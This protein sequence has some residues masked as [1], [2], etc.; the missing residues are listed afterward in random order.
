MEAGRRVE[1]VRRDQAQAGRRPR[2][3]G[4]RGSFHTRGSRQRGQTQE[5]DR[6]DEHRTHPR[7]VRLDRHAGYRRERPEAV[8]GDPPPRQ[9]V[10]AL[11]L[12]AA[13]RTRHPQRQ[14]GSQT[15]RRQHG[16]RADLR[17]RKVARRLQV[18]AAAQQAAVHP[19]AQTEPYGRAYHRRRRHG[20]RQ[21]HELH[22]IRGRAVGQHRLTGKGPPRKEDRGAGERASGVRA[23]QVVE[24]QPAGIYARKNRGT[25]RKDR[26]HRKRPRSFQEPC[27]TQRGRIV[28][29]PYHAGRGGEQRSAVHRQTT[30]PYRKNR[31]YGN[32]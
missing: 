31:R 20:R 23:R 25:R 21:R 24:P 29:Q 26:T 19:P 16:G 22:G 6:R 17:R 11:G 4:F 10:A 9:S 30:E 7:I 1:R 18:R 32:G 5:D 27:G 14:R 28:S 12:G 8:R 13:R 15:L 2:Y 3:S